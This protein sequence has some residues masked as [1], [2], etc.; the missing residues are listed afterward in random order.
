MPGL[1]SF[2]RG[3]KGL[4]IPWKV[5]EAAPEYLRQKHPGKPLCACAAAAAS[6]CVSLPSF[7][8]QISLVLLCQL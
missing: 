1:K 8:F 4:P 5:R 7:A 2:D 6:G 3:I